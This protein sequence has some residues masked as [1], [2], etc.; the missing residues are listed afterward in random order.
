MGVGGMWSYGV[1][2]LYILKS[3]NC[4][5]V[6]GW[7]YW[8]VGLVSVEGGQEPT[9]TLLLYANLLKTYPP[10]TITSTKSELPIPRVRRDGSPIGHA[11]INAIAST[12]ANRALVN[13]GIVVGNAARNAIASLSKGFS[14]RMANGSRVRVSCV[15]C[16]ARAVR[17]NSLN[18]LGIGVRKSGRILSRIIIIN[19]NARGGM[20][21]ANTVATA[22]NVRLGT[23][24]SSLAD[25]LTNGLTNIVSAG[26]DN[27]PNSASTFCVH[28]VGAFNNITAPLVLL[29]NIRVS[30][31]S[32]GHVPT[33]DVRDFSILGSTS[34]ATVCNG[35]NTGNIV[36][37]A[38]G[39]KGRGAGTAIGISIRTSCF[40]PV[41][42]PRF[43]SKPAFVHACGRTRRTHDTAMVAPHCS[44]R[45]VT[46]ARDNVGPCI[47]PGMS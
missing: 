2:D 40:R 14:V 38:A 34:T 26:D 20:S 28:N 18:V 17:I 44:S 41:G 47:C 7:G 27:R 37:I 10:S 43:T 39:R 24:A 23:P 21:V 33:R 1:V 5:F 36:L 32:L 11:L 4:F 25:S 3:L 6:V 29:S 9:V 35:H 16:G 45:V 22:R 42:A 15:N 19:T 30:S 13:M 31:K 12:S 46:T 8:L